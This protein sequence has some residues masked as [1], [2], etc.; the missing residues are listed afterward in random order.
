LKTT[1]AI[2]LSKIIISKE[3]FT[4][5]LSNLYGWVNGNAQTAAAC[6]TACGAGDGTDKKAACGTA[7]GAGDGEGK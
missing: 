7:C 2:G 6:G 3:E 5:A 1:K 4:M